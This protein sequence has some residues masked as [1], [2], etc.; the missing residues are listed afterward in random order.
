[1]RIL[2]TFAVQNE[3]APWRRMREFRQ[4]DAFDSITYETRI[5]EMEVCV[6]LTGIGPERASRSFATLVWG[7]PAYDFCISAGLAGALKS[8]YAPGQIVAARDAVSEEYGSLFGSEKVLLEVAENCGA[9]LV[10]KFLTVGRIVRTS[11]EKQ[12]LGATYDVV[13]M[14]SAEILG[15]APAWGI[16]AIA[17]RA[18]SDAAG[19]DMP[20]DFSHVMSAEGKVSMLGVLGEVS[21]NPA[22]LA[23]L[24]RF[25]NA[26]RKAA[27][28]LAS[29]LDRYVL[30]L[31]REFAAPKVSTGMFAL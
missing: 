11:E 22:S 18:I 20:I 19:E 25:G 31:A 23:P 3:F 26:S 9:R 2:V 27:A 17:V 6:L 21:K 16:R 30:A 4:V 1:M 5:G 10:D 7:H 8:S 15:E 13:E 28:N 14:E 12:L 29:F 24:I